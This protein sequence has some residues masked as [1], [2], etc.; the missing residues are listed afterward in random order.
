ME[1]SSVKTSRGFCLLLLLFLLLTV[2]TRASAQH[3]DPDTSDPFPEVS[4][5]GVFYLTYQMGEN[6]GEDFSRFAVTRSYLT[7]RVELLPNL[8]GRITMDSH[9]DDEG[10]M[11]VRLKYAYAKYD[12]G[13]WGDLT[14]VGLEGGIVH[15]VW[16]DFEEHVDL[17]RMR[18]QMFMERSGMFNSADIGLTLSGG[19]GEDL[20]EEYKDEVN[21]HYAARYGS[22]AVGVYNGGGYHGSE[23]NE[24][25]AVQG[26]LTVRPLPDVIP[27]FQLSGLVVLGEGNQE[28]EPDATPNWQA[29]NAMASYQFPNGTFTA[30]YSW[31]EGNQKGSWTEPGD[32][33]EATNYEGYS[34]FG[35]YKMGPHWR[36]IGGFDDLDRT[37]GSSD[38]SFTRVHGGI[39]YDFGG[40][41]ILLF[42]LDR[43]N[44]ADSE[45]ETDTRFQVV[46]QIKF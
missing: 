26:R 22:F 21:D 32:T 43:R 46:M 18:D 19:I 35:E 23:Q 39:G 13:D 1:G 10:D 3:A 20:P 30:Q 5:E 17:Y 16:L 38:L 27:G 33:S 2:V 7:A 31:G 29:Y 28:G 14:G 11:K 15:M 41:N 9:Q 45:L 4:F 40:Q 36:L 24:N 37:P 34:L 12:F 6:G 42:D 44:W 25:K 8:S